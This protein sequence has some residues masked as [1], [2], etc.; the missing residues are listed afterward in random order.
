MDE[1]EHRKKLDR[2]NA[3]ARPKNA[4]NVKRL[5]S[6]MVFRTLDVM[7]AIAIAPLMRARPS[8]DV[9]QRANEINHWRKMRI[10]KPLHEK[11]LCMLCDHVFVEDM[12]PMFVRVVGGGTTQPGTM[13]M[14]GICHDCVEAPDLKKR[15]AAN[16]KETLH[17][18]NTFDVDGPMG[19]A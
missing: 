5:Y 9:W 13:I 16:L 17:C 18:E 3:D 14:S 11:P 7:Q 19:L 6:S 8:E 15:I 1:A 4:L 10:V 2:F 12:P